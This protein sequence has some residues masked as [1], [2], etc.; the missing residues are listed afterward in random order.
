MQTLNMKAT[1]LALTT[2]AVAAYVVCAV[3]RP[4]FPAWPMYDVT[5]WQAFFPGFA[6]T[7]SG[8]LIGLVWMVAYAIFA[9]VV[10][11]GAYNFFTG[12]QAL[13][14]RQ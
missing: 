1:T 2:L 9:S 14:E 12:R 13:A 6:W 7:L 3:F 4:L 11:V 5:M 8:V 10:F